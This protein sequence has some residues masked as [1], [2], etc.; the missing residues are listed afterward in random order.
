MTYHGQMTGRYGSGRHGRRALGLVGG[1]KRLLLILICAAV[2]LG[3]LV[4][5]A[6]MR[7]TNSAPSE[8]NL[9]TFTVRRQDLTIT[10]TESGS[11][12]AQEST[13]IMC[14]VEGRQ[15]RG[16]DIA[17]IVPE[18][19]VVTQEDVE[20]GKILCQLNASELQDTYN[21]E[22]ITFSTS[23]AAYT[24]AQE[25]Y[26]I[27]QKQNES[28][29]KAAELAERF[30]LMDLQKYLGD[31]IAEQVVARTKEDP[32][33]GIDIASLLKEIED[34]NSGSEASQKLRE[35]TGAIGLAAANLEKAVDTLKWTEE[36]YKKQY[37][38]E[39][40]LMKDKLEKQ[41]LE[42]E[43]EKAEIALRLFKRYEFPKQVEQLLSDYQEAG[44]QLERTLAQA[45]SKL[46]QAEAKLEGAEASYNLQK[47]QV[48]RLEKQIAGCTIR[49]PSPGIV[50]YG[51]SADW[52]RRREDPIEVGDMVRKGEKIFTI[53]NSDLMG[54]ELR[55]HESSVDKVRP[56]LPTT[57][58]IEAFPD[59][60]FEGEVLKV[61]PLPEPQ[62]GF[63]DAG[64][65]VY[66]TNVSI[67]GRYD[68][69]KPGMSAKV[70]ILIDELQDVTIVPIQVVANREGKK[71]CYVA[72]ADG[73]RQREVKTGQFNDTFV[74]IL[75]GLEVGEQVLLNPPR[76]AEPSAVAEM[77]RPR[78]APQ[79][80]RPTEGGEVAQREEEPQGSG[81]AQGE[82]PPQAEGAGVSGA[83]PEKSG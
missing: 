65:K 42:I 1:G 73:P 20:K 82:Q 21:Q 31:T 53:P 68:F 79:D 23:K 43:K 9:S 70:E 49:A 36:L 51:T 59:R 38:A 80:E 46:A 5:L 15:G 71:V 4:L 27:Q 19:T 75:E 74:E 48:A 41:R 47:E 35:L 39:T 50:I 55:V 22:Q 29:V 64:V 67:N 12:E 72:T 60:K 14:E 62:R 17:S 40:E 58:T 3:G 63:L 24:E 56:G 30:G 44:R 26:A 34:P 77:E 11:V 10:V 37:V 69:I 78:E 7:S 57:V 25:A 45:R 33:S 66:T 32:N 8:A 52:W 18:G 13:D 54:V 28:D 61:A 81:P 83:G 6:A 16:V 76:L 2:V